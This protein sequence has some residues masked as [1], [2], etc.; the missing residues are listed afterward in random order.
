MIGEWD[1]GGCEVVRATGLVDR[2]GLGC[3]D[4]LVFFIVLDVLGEK[5][6]WLSPRVNFDHF[7]QKKDFVLQPLHRFCNRNIIVQTVS[8]LEM[9]NKMLPVIN[10]IYVHF[11]PP[12]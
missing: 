12:D 7:P 8:D 11:A 5:G 3:L 4:G 10:F 2:G 9:S 6:D 1:E